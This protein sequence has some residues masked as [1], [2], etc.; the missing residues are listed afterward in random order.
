M[1]GR[2][3]KNLASLFIIAPENRPGPKRKLIFQQDN[4]LVSGRGNAG[5]PQD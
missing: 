2:F 5:I 3:T 4:L 1:V